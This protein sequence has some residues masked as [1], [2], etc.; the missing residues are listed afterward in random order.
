MFSII[1]SFFQIFLEVHI[2]RVLFVT[3][4]SR[5][6]AKSSRRYARLVKVCQFVPED[7]TQLFS[8]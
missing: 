1:G 3:V 5:I 4:G 8:L 2:Y 7:A 6:G